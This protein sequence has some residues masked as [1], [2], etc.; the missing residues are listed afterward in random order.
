LVRS[1]FKG[2]RDVARGTTIESPE[3]EMVVDGPHVFEAIWETDYTLLYVVIVVAALTSVAAMF[4]AYARFRGGGTLL[5][6]LRRAAAPAKAAARVEE[7]KAKIAEIDKRIAK[8]DL[9]FKT[10]KISE[11]AYRELIS[12][13]ETERRELERELRRLMEDAN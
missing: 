4:V 7:I 12:R 13:Y 8:A 1:V 5:K 11:R 10:G 3:F 6:L 9:L 2:W